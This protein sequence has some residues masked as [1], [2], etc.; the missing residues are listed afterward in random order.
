VTIRCLTLFLLLLLGACDPGDVVLLAPDK[1][2]SDAPAL[3]LHAVIDTPY[4]DVAEGLGWT[5][6]VPQAQVRVHLMKEPYNETYWSV[7]T[8]DS[9]GIAK[10]ADLLGGLYEVQVTRQLTTGEIAQGDTAPHVLA[11]GRV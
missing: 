3:T 4:M 5:A 7:A 1:S 9:A 10:F 2:P 11:G 8:A 6:G